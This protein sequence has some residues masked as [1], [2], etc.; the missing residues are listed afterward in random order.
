MY[1]MEEKKN[2]KKAIQKT[3]SI[4]KYQIKWLLEHKEISLSGLL[5]KNIDSLMKGELQLNNFQPL[6]TEKDNAIIQCTVS[7]YVYQNEWLKIHKEI[8]LSGLV[9]RCLDE[10]INS[11]NYKK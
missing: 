3:I 5:Q 6:E 1:I 7:I 8:S 9:K 4:Y 10:I 2:K 11:Y